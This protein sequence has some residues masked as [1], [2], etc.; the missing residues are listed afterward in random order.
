MLSVA[1]RSTDGSAAAAS[2]AASNDLARGLLIRPISGSQF[3][4]RALAS[5]HCA[6]IPKVQIGIRGSIIAIHHDADRSSARASKIE[7]AV[8]WRRAAAGGY[9]FDGS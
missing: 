4:A 1:E 3:V 9:V 5:S 2:L 6:A 7:A 8:Q